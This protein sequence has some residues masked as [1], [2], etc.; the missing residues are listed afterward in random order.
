M[1]GQC[2]TFLSLRHETLSVYHFYL[3]DLRKSNQISVKT[4]L[5]VIIF[6]GR[7]FSG[8]TRSISLEFEQQEKKNRHQEKVFK[9]SKANIASHAE[10]CWT[11][12]DVF[13]NWCKSTLEKR[14][15]WQNVNEPE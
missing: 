1:D 2:V 4:R 8:Q 10:N 5:P 3:E 7:F 14:S 6:Y 12:G 9:G 11:K 15:Q 13:E